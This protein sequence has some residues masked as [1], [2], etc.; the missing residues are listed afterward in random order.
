MANGVH[1][2]PAQAEQEIDELQLSVGWR[3]STDATTDEQSANRAAVKTQ[4]RGSRSLR[5]RNRIVRLGLD[6]SP[7]ALAAGLVI[8]R[9]DLALMLA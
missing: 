1:L 2:L 7:M 4:R 6:V 5:P 3:A 8:G 9:P